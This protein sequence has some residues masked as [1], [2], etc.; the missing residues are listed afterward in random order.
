MVNRQQCYLD[1]HTLELPEQRKKEYRLSI[2][3]FPKFEFEC[4]S[5]VSCDATW[6]TLHGLAS[7][8]EEVDSSF[9]SSPR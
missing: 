6:H 5:L 2:F 8:F 7:H 9:C 3:M 4:W 1:E